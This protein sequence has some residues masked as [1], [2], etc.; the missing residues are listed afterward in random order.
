MTLARK[1]HS[2]ERLIASVKELHN[3]IP[4]GPAHS[5]TPKVRACLDEIKLTRTPAQIYQ[6]MISDENP[7]PESAGSGVEIKPSDDPE[8]VLSA[9][10]DAYRAELENLSRLIELRAVLEKLQQGIWT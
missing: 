5:F 6:L 4:L 1:I 9:M 2:V 7:F 8:A 10:Y 3:S